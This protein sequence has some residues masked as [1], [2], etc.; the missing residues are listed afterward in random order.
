[1]FTAIANQGLIAQAATQRALAVRN[2]ILAAQNFYGW[3]SAQ[4][5]ADLTGI[6][7]SAGDIG[8]MRSM[9]ADLNALSNVYHGLA[10]GGAYVLP[11]S[12]INSSVMVI[13]AQ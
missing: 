11:Y 3:I 8:L 2:D 5:D 10:P 13:G 6:G 7:F 1:M 9:A 4:A 12:F